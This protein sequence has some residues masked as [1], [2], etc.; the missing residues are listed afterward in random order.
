M[1]IISVSPAYNRFVQYADS[2]M[3][4]PSPTLIALI[5]R[6][7]IFILPLLW[8]SGSVF[9]WKK[10][11][12]IEAVNRNEILLG[13]TSVTI[14]AGMALLC[15]YLLAGVLPFFYIGAFIR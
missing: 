4:L 12:D 10:I 5:L 14:M 8:I 9:I 1:S 3:E 13:L 2:G 11:K 15:Y 7:W 6:P